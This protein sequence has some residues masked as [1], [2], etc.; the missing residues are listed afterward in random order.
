MISAQE[1]AMPAEAQRAFEKGTSLLVKGDAEGSIPLLRRA[2]EKA[3]KS[4][5]CHHNLGLALY[6]LGQLDES[7]LEF[8]RSID[9]TGGSFAPSLFA[10]SMILYRNGEFRQAESVIQNGL[11]MDPGSGVGKYCLALVQYS[12]GRID[13][14]ERNARDAVSRV[15]AQTDAY[16]LLARIH[17]RSHNPYAV[18]AD[19]QAYLKL[20]PHGAFQE[21]AHKLLERA[22][23]NLSH[24]SASLH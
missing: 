13:E 24:M 4:Y 12:L 9:L 23:L 6:R 19:V 16:M 2:L 8:Q 3:P 17:E 15:N 5:R 11:L 21:D 14:A 7:A 18:I 10:L 22:Q 20:D 1:L